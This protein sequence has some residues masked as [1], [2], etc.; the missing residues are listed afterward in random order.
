MITGE[1]QNILVS[2][3]PRHRQKLLL[4]DADTEMS[5]GELSIPTELGV[6]RRIYDLAATE[7]HIICLASWSLI[8]W[9]V[10]SCISKDI[11]SIKPLV[12]HDFESVQELSLIHI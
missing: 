12:L 1:N 11:N 10:P 7:T 2:V 6:Q 4:W 3:E 9:N 5:I 8:V